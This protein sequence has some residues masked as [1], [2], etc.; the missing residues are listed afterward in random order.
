MAHVDPA[1][2]PA[3]AQPEARPPDELRF[4]ATPARRGFEVVSKT[5]VVWATC[6]RPDYANAVATLLSECSRERLA[7]FLADG[8]RT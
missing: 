4:R 3:G 7:R 5:G 8:D 1:P 6:K 2:V